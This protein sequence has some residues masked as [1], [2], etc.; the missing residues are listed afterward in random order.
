MQLRMNQMDGFELLEICR[1]ELFMKRDLQ[2][3]GLILLLICC[4]EPNI[5][6][7]TTNLSRS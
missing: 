4:V 7:L 3:L 5:C 6:T 1:N 2:E